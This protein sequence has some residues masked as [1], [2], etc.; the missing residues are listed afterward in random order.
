MMP[1][2]GKS[3]S[4]RV[5]A[6]G[7][8][9]VEVMRSEVDQPLHRPGEFVGPFPSGAPA[10][11]IDAVA[12]LGAAAGFIGVVGGDAFGDCVLD[13]LRADGV[14][15]THVRV[16]PGYTTGIAFVSYRSD[17]SRHFVFHLP[18]SAAALLGPDD[19][20]EAFVSGAA[21]LHV[22][23]SA[24]AIGPRTREACYK[25]VA[26]CK[27][28]GGRI[29]FDPN[30]RPEL[31]GVERARE[32]C[33]PVLQRC[34]LLLPSGLEATMLTDDVDQVVACRALVASGVP[35]V[36]LKRGSE[37]STVFTA[38]QVIEVPPLPVQ[39]V[40]PTGA[41]DCYG[42]AFVVGLLE[43]WPL[44]KVARFANVAGA[45]SVTRQGP[46]EGIPR[47]E[48]VLERM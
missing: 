30:L 17:G 34:D 44:D 32:I 24:L 8:L 11:L 4:P 7:E 38:E 39:E 45:L 13:R 42:G 27:A 23:G 36:A 37:G 48:Q 21:F 43:G 10:I 6:L 3:V 5:I 9:L 33:R 28:G 19:V 14:D 18:Q 35:I 29:S 1:S 26:L 15:T 40:D 22:T 16:A 25:A 46:M 47:R 2:E 41:G 20:D 31:L 12:R